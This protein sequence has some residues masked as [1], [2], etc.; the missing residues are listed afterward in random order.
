MVL[1]A[2]KSNDSQIFCPKRSNPT[3]IGIEEHGNCA[4]IDELIWENEGHVG[5]SEWGCVHCQ[6][7]G[8]P[9]LETNPYL[10]NLL[11][12]VTIVMINSLHRDTYKD[13]K[14]ATYEHMLNVL[15]IAGESKFDIQKIIYWLFKHS[16]INLKELGNLA[17]KLNVDRD[18]SKREMDN[19]EEFS[20]GEKIPI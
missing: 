19:L 18:L 1:R 6:E 9:E 14:T 10:K 16:L 17:T 5:L 15:K 4:I 13:R 3:L 8:K 12:E 2:K 11:K 20:R 7:A